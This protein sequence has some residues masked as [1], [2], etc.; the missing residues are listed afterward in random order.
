MTAAGLDGT[1]S[2]SRR[3]ASAGPRVAASSRHVSG[4]LGSCS[5]RLGSRS[6]SRR[7]HHRPRRRRH[8]QHSQ[9]A[10]HC[11]RTDLN[12]KAGG[13]A[14][15]QGDGESR[16]EGK[17]QL[18]ALKADPLARCPGRSRVKEAGE[19]GTVAPVPK[20][21]SSGLAQPSAPLTH[22]LMTMDLCQAAAQEQLLQVSTLQ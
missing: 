1:G 10:L 12:R 13:Q 7:S 2:P 5:C 8:L 20:A 3:R 4:A 6:R 11:C 15:A 19:Q 16:K 21:A 17:S 9:N 18:W 14:E 22:Q